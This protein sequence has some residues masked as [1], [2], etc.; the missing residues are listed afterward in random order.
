MTTTADLNTDFTQSDSNDFTATAKK[1]IAIESHAIQQLHAHIDGTF[2]QACEC[3][4]GIKGRVVVTGIGKSG[5][6]GRK[7]SATLASTGTPSFFMHPAEACHGDLGM[8]TQ[9]DCLLAIS[10]SGNNEEIELLLPL[11]KRLGTPIIAMTAQPNSV[12]GTTADICLSIAVPEEACP[13]GLAPTSSTTATLVMG[14]A[15]AVSLLRAKGF[16]ENDFAFSHPGGTLGKRLM[17]TVEELMHTGPK[18]PKVSINTTVEKTLLE[19]SEK[20]LGMTAVVDA[21]GQLSGIFTDGDLRRT[22]LKG[23]DLYNTPISAEMTPDG[24]HTHPKM[25]AAEALNLMETHTINGLIVVDEQRRPVGALNM[26]D[27]LRA[28]LV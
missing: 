19:M 21:Q 28:K 23:I 3:M 9:E 25:L 12:L 6:I 20:G 18:L 26:Q 13:L 1:V 14:D 10:Y 17:L 27:L 2:Q 24:V 16:N 15:L 11:I 7:I 22:L 8:L 5:H 4:I